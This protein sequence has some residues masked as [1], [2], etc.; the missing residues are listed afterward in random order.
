[1]GIPP[2]PP[3]GKSSSCPD[4]LRPPPPPPPTFPLPGTPPPD[5]RGSPA[6]A[7][8][9]GDGRLKEDA[10]STGS[11]YGDEDG[12]AGDEVDDAGGGSASSTGSFYVDIGRLTSVHAC[13]A[14]I[15]ELDLR[16]LDLED[17]IGNVASEA[18]ATAHGAETTRTLVGGLA[19]RVAALERALEDALR[20][21]AA[22]AAP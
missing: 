1:M 18:L 21:R 3:A 22:S 12:S 13:G 20:P 2:A 16:P 14:A 6:A 4:S 11:F 5:G 17:C 8:G 9:N 15:G 7:A 19:T 10:S